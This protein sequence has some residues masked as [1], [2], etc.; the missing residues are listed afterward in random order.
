MEGQIFRGRMAG[1][2]MRGGGGQSELVS[3]SATLSVEAST[4]PRR[5]R[6]R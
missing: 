3:L 1:G 5:Q 4:Q 6:K 2:T